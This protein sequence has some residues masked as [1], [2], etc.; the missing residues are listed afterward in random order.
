MLVSLRWLALSALL[1]GCLGLLLPTPSA[2]SGSLS[3]FKIKDEGAFFSK[4]AI[5]KAQK[6]IDEIKDKYD[7]DLLIETRKKMPEGET[8]RTWADK[9]YRERAVEGILVL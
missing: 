4:E 7:I 3:S 9:V 8:I 6:R 2:A 1:A 5:A